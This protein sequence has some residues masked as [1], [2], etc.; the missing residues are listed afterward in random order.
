MQETL[1]WLLR[2][3]FELLIKVPGYFIVRLLHGNV[4]INEAFVNDGM[5]GCLVVVAGITFWA[6]VLASV[7]LCSR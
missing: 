6:L 5:E 7:W 2:V 1:E 4:T 3:V